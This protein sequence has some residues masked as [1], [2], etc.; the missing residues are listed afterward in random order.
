[1]SSVRPTS[2]VSGAAPQSPPGHPAV[3][4]TKS[5]ATT[6]STPPTRLRTTWAGSVT[7]TRVGS[8]TLATRKDAA[9]DG[10]ATSTTPPRLVRLASGASVTDP[11]A[12]PARTG[13]IFTAR[14]V[15]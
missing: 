9:S 15:L 8:V 2:S 7:F 12:R 3:R 13:P 11:P 1:M 10:D 14:V 6:V 4:P 5:R